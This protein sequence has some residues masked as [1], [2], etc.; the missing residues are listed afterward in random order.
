MGRQKEPK[1]TR[2]PV[3]EDFGR[4]HDDLASGMLWGNCVGHGTLATAE[5]ISHH[6]RWHVNG[7]MK[8]QSVTQWKREP[9]HKISEANGVREVMG[10]TD[11]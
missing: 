7:L 3:H 8:D 5:W 1:P 2:T 4:D 11:Q 6:N 10:F 9:L